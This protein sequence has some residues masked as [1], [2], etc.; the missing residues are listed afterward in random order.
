M[1]LARHVFGFR[2]QRKEADVLLMTLRL[3]QKAMSKAEGNE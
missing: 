3:E 1:A 2:A